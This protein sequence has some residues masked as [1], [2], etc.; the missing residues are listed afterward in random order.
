MGSAVFSTE[1][2]EGSFAVTQ[3]W[4][5]FVA[6]T[7]PLTVIVVLCWYFYNRTAD[8]YRLYTEAA[9]KKNAPVFI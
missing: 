7:V 8:K 3:L 5:P 4:L 2:V 6:T 9:E 1:T